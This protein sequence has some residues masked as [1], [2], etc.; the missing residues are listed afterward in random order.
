MKETKSY[1]IEKGLDDKLKEIADSISWR[2]KSSLAEEAIKD[3]IEKY[4]QRNK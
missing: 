1:S 3:L 4:E 2:S